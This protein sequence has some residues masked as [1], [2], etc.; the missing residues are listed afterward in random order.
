MTGLSLWCK[1]RK[2]GKNTEKGKEHSLRKMKG[3][4]R[5]GR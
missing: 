5:E 2:K 3:W 4:G 1:K